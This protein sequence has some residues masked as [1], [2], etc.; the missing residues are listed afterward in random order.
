MGK[1]ISNSYY[2]IMLALTSVLTLF[3]ASC[4]KD[5]DR[6][7]EVIRRQLY[8]NSKIMGNADSSGQSYHY[9]I[10]AGDK[11]VFDRYHRRADQES[12]ADDEY[13]EKIAFEVDANVSEF[14]F[15]DATL[16]NANPVFAYMCYCVNREGL[17]NILGSIQ[18]KKNGNG[19]D[20]VVDLKYVFKV[21]TT[22]G[23]KYDTVKVAFTESYR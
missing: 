17:E 14:S 4:R 21:K 12:V 11:I 16:K 19:W 6:H 3:L 2:R 22:G 18:G 7:K 9:T 1:S 20:V 10:V 8:T 13:E 23:T 15:K 5:D